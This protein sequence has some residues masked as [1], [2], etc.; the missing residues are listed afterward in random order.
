M[1]LDIMTKQQSREFNFIRNF[2]KEKKSELTIHLL[3]KDPPDALLKNDFVS[4][5]IEVVELW[6]ERN[7]KPIIEAY[8]KVI[9][10]AKIEFEKLSDEKLTVSFKFR[11][12]LDISN[13]RYKSFGLEIGKWIFDNS[14]DNF[15]EYEHSKKVE[16]PIQNINQLLEINFIN[17]ENC[18]KHG[19]HY[20][21]GFVYGGPL[22]SDQLVS[23]VDKKINKIPN[24]N[25][26]HLYDEKWLLMVA[27]GESS[28]FFSSFPISNIDWTKLIGFDKI[29]ILDNISFNVFECY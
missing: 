28:S 20:D 24:W 2:L 5:G 1:N 27:T 7:N 22:C 8:E 14:P 9:K 29:F 19:W 15:N 16:N 23:V 13:N 11:G 10:S 17:C 26:H 3:E 18:A 25:S 21:T 12:R 6:H 4:I